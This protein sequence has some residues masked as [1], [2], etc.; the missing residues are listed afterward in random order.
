ML[1]SIRR[2]VIRGGRV[3]RRMSNQHFVVAR[4]PEPSETI[5]PRCPI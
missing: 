4:K 3:K 5:Q 1:I 2:L